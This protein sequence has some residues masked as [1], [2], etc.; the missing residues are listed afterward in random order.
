MWV[1]ACDT[2]LAGDGHHYHPW[3]LGLAVVSLALGALVWLAFRRGPRAAQS[4]GRIAALLLA[5]GP[6]V[7]FLVIIGS[8]EGHRVPCG[9]K[10]AEAVR[11]GIPCTNH[12]ARV[13]VPAA[14]LTV[15]SVAGGAGF[16]I[17]ATVVTIR[18]RG[19]TEPDVSP[20]TAH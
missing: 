8:A 5:L 2:C 13:R 14:T 10:L 19:E 7:A 15:G 1:L 16:G 18:R 3:F 4:L 11:T 12:R 9:A 20:A 17:A 6:T